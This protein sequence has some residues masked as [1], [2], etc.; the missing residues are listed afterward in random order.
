M[1][2]VQRVQGDIDGDGQIETIEGT[3]DSRTIVR[4]NGTVLWQTG[5]GWIDGWPDGHGTFLLP[6]I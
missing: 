3:S 4:R 2:V 5:P 6:L 1:S